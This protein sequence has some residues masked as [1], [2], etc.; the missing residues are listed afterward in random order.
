MKAITYIITFIVAGFLSLPWCC[1]G[2]SCLESREAG[3]KSETPA[4]CVKMLQ[5]EIQ[6]SQQQDGEDAPDHECL[7]SKGKD[8][9]SPVAFYVPEFTSEGLQIEWPSIHDDR[10]V[11]DKELHHGIAAAPELPPPPP[12]RQVFCVLIL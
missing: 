2:A 11:G 1:C 8:A 4:C 3:S 6:D 9:V 7:C 12:I 10:S 5:G